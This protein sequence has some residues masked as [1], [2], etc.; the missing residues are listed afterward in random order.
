[1]QPPQN[2]QGTDENDGAG[3]PARRALIISALT[4][5]LGT[6]VGGV[7]GYRS[8]FSAEQ[9]NAS[10]TPTEEPGDS[11]LAEL[12]RLAKTAPIDELLEWRLVFVNSLTKDYPRDPILWQGMYRLAMATIERQSFKDRALF[13]RFLAQAIEAGDPKLAGDVMPLVSSLR[14]IR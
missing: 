14:A 9:L 7:W 13:A 5:A 8:A 1:M 4:F 2:G 12:R 3:V 6:T 10:G 11:E